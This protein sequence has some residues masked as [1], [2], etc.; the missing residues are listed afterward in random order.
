[1]FYVSGH[2]QRGPFPRSGCTFEPPRNLDSRSHPQ[3]TGSSGTEGSF[4]LNIPETHKFYGAP[5]G[6]CLF[7]DS[8]FPLPSLSLSLL[9]RRFAV[10]LR[11]ELQRALLSPRDRQSSVTFASSV[12][13]VTEGSPQTS[14]TDHTTVKYKFTNK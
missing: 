14:R 13:D 2:G 1:M 12:R 8:H 5:A 9:R 3:R 11:G 6:N 7:N 10:K 4:T